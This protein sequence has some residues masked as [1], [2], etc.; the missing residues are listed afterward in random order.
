MPYSLPRLCGH[1]RNVHLDQGHRVR[2]RC[3]YC[4]TALPAPASNKEPATWFAK[5]AITKT[6]LALRR[7]SNDTAVITAVIIVEIALFLAMGKWIQHA[8][9]A[10][11]CAAALVLVPVFSFVGLPAIKRVEKSS[12]LVLDGSTWQ[13]TGR[14]DTSVGGT[15]EGSLGLAQ[16]VDAQTDGLLAQRVEG[17]V[18]FRPESA[19]GRPGGPQGS[20][21]PIAVRGP[22]WV[23]DMGASTEVAISDARARQLFAVPASVALPP[24]LLIRSATIESGQRCRLRGTLKD[25]R[26][27]RIDNK[28]ASEPLTSK[29]GRAR[30]LAYQGRSIYRTPATISETVIEGAPIVLSRV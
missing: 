29:A 7:V 23:E 1:C 8:G 6:T 4:G 9:W 18:T 14:A 15:L 2:A 5:R 17:S 3:P 22:I 19:L 20:T 27:E 11:A 21:R 13:P 12:A 28:D 24:Q 25:V 26:R 30:E 16:L 10:V